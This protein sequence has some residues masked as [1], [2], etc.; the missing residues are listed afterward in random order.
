MAEKALSIENLQTA[1]SQ[2]NTK[3]KAWV[4]EQI[5]KLETITIEWVDTLPSTGMSTSTIYLLRNESST[6]ENNIY[7]EYVYNSASGWEII[8]QVDVGSVDLT[9]Y[10]TKE[11]VDNLVD[12]GSSSLTNY[13]EEEI[14]TMVT[15]IWSE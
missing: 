15:E 6:A 11:E 12:G 4:T 13:T 1:M 2:N 10:Y 8:G 5:G 14:T 9:N 7:D 3:M